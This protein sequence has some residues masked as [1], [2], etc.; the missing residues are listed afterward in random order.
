MKSRYSKVTLSE[1]TKKKAE[2][3]RTIKETLAKTKRDPK[4]FEMAK[5]EAKTFLR[6]ISMQELEVI[7]SYLGIKP[8]DISSNDI[9]EEDYEEQVRD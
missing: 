7:C 3:L 5:L 6:A 4:L 9:M 2:S 8:N 1:D